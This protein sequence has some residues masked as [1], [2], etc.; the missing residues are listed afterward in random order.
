VTDF[1]DA[2]CRLGT[3]CIANKFNVLQYVNQ[4]AQLY[5]IDLSGRMLLGKT[6]DYG[7]FTATGLLNYSR[8]ENLSTGDN[9]YN[10]M[11]LNMKLAFTQKL[12]KWTNT[13]E[14]QFVAA[15][16]RISQVRNEVATGGYSLVNLRSSYEW[17]QL[18][19][20]VGLDNLFDKA[21]ALPLG[22]TYVGQGMTMSINGV[23]WG[24]A[25][26]GMGRSLYTGLSFKF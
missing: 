16:S 12:G 14:T 25:V 23:P 26:P 2:Q 19:L 1:I 6:H 4:T 15:K 13:L 11:P 21:Y 17:K 3:T 10:I 5:G 22:G 18:R 7:N 24:I 8:G 20:D 9:L